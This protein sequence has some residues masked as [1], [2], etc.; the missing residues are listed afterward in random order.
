MGRAFLSGYEIPLE[1]LC[2]V[3]IENGNIAIAEGDAPPSKGEALRGKLDALS[4]ANIAKAEELDA[5]KAAGEYGAY[6]DEAESGA[7]GTVYGS[8]AL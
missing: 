2:A 7:G 1:A 6:A 5:L 4:L 3:S 8:G